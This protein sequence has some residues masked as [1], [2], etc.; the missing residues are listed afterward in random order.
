MRAGVAQGGL[1]SSVFFSLYVNYM[2]TPSQHVELV[3][4]ADATAIIAT[5][6]K[7][8]LLVSDLESYLRPFDG[9]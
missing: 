7:S 9:S 3:L 4:Y 2:P 6:R 8:A 1:I 5:S